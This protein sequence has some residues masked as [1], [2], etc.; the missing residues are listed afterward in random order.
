MLKTIK[1][2][3][4]P[5]VDGDSTQVFNYLKINGGLLTVP[6]A[7]G[8]ANISK[9][10][11]Y[12]QSLLKS[13]IVI[14]D[15]GFMVLV[16][17]ILNKNKINKI[18]GLNFIN[19]FISLAEKIK[20]DKIFLINPSQIDNDFNLSYLNTKGLGFINGYVAPFYG[21]EVEDTILLLM[22]EEFKPRWILINI[23]GGTQEKLGLY[24]K[25][26][27]SYK[28]AILCTG[29]AIAFKTGRQAKIPVWVDN[30]YLGWLSRCLFKPT[31]Y[32]PRYIKA[33]GVVKYI[34]KYKSQIVK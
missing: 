19:F 4:I 24:L 33:F 8:L 32:I 11:E 5:F 17:N 34:I 25:N 20:D 15:S 12:Y 3:G 6:A 9:D 7:P 1:I 14:P 30:F 10:K 31:L 2:L 13:D 26:K 29:A 28:P 23:G 18:S 22:I 21:N 27:L 16:W